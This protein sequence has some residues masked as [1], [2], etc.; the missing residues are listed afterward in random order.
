[1]NPMSTEEARAYLVTTGGRW[2]L[3]EFAG[4]DG[5]ESAETAENTGWKK[6]AA[7]G[8]NGWDLGCWPLVVYMFRD[9]DGAFEL[10][11]H[12]E[13]DIKVWRFSTNEMRSALVD[14]LAFWWWQ[15]EEQAWTAGHSID[16]IPDHLRGPFSWARLDAEK[17][18]S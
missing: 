5:Y 10:A 2:T 17:V 6:R 3:P 4:D 8:L 1:M 14:T 13:G 16:A 18:A 11:E 12:V 9:H 7:W 15:N